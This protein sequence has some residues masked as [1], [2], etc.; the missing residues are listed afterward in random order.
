M[1]LRMSRIFR[2]TRKE[3]GMWGAVGSKVSRVVTTFR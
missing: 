1:R 3:L 2:E